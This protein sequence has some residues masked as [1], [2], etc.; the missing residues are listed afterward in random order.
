MEQ[1]MYTAKNGRLFYVVFKVEAPV[2]KCSREAQEVCSR[3]QEQWR[4]SS[5]CSF[6]LHKGTGKRWTA[7]FDD[8]FEQILGDTWSIYKKFWSTQQRFQI[9]GRKLCDKS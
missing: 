9:P 5:S 2:M 8:G 4:S 1:L 3:Q 7:E 6:I